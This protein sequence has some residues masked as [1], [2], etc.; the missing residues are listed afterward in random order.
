MKNIALFSVIT[1]ILIF[2]KAWL[3]I[4]YDS[5]VFALYRLAILMLFDLGFSYSYWSIINKINIL[6]YNASYDFIIY[7]AYIVIS[8]VFFGLMIMQIDYSISLIKA[9]L[10]AVLLCWFVNRTKGEQVS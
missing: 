7:T 10:D 5:I 6:N 4:S 8:G 9:V 1:V 3:A 2:E